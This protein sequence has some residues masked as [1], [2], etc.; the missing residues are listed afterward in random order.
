M[1][2][3]IRVDLEGFYQLS[4]CR[5]IFPWEGNYRYK[6]D[7]SLDAA[8]WT[9]AVDRTQTVRTDPVRQDVFDPGTVARYV[10]I[11]FMAVPPGARAHLCEFELHGVL[12]AG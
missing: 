11:T 5:V 7:V 3:W 1:T 2:A 12:S 4:S 10:R 6:I 8:D 9:L